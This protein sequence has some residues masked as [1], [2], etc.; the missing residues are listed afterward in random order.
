[1]DRAT[2]DRELSGR[3]EDLGYELVEVR[4]GGTA[5]RPHL[6][7]RI[8]RPS[9]GLRHGVT[10]VDCALVSRALEAWLDERGVGEGRYILEVSS[11]GVDRPLKRLAEWKRFMGVP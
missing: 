5:R 11:P 10:V 6:T 4:H 7:V 9:V 1:M 2:L 3:V 8:D